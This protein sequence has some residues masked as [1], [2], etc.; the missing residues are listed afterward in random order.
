L[1][2]RNF[3]PLAK[4]CVERIDEQIQQEKLEEFSPLTVDEVLD[5]IARAS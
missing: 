1:A 5:R 3:E 2:S 4:F